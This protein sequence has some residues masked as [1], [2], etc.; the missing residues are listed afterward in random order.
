MLALLLTI[1]LALLLFVAGDTGRSF[2]HRGSRPPEWA[3]WAFTL[4]LLLAL[5]HTVLAFDI[6]H[7]WVHDDAV[8][9]TAQQTEAVFGVSV[10]WGVYVNYVFYGVWLTDAVWWRVSP[11]LH[12]RPAAVTWALRIFY[13]III[14]NAAVIF[15]V[16]WRRILGLLLVSWLVR[17]W[18]LRQAG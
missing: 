11:D 3:W 6:V 9:S 14:L 8:L 16:G 18:T 1:W 12:R 4:G 5:I 15:A 7:N 17:V 10:G 2:A 13:L